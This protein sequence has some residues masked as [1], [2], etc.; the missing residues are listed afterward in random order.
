MPVNSKIVLI[1]GHCVVCNGFAK[2][3]LKRDK[4]N[5]F[6]LGTL[7]S[8]EGQELQMKNKVD[9]ETD[10]IIYIEGEAFIH[11][12]AALKI[13]SQLPFYGWVKLFFVFPKFIRDG[14]YKLIARNRYNWF[15][16]KEECLIPTK[17]E[18]ERFI[19]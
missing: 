11:S 3:I 14:V 15:G 19:G 1:D 8:P 6:K 16:R 10:S 5:I 9:N 17:E 2:F 12:N 13:I 4:K 7:Q 18:R